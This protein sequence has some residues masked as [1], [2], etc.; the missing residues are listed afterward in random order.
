MESTSIHPRVKGG[1]TFY[2]KVDTSKPRKTKASRYEKRA[3]RL[4]LRITAA[5]ST[6]KSLPSNA[7]PEAYRIPGSMN[8]H[9]R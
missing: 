5:A 9:K 4:N 8:Q 2:P 1:V 6:R 7:N 3:R